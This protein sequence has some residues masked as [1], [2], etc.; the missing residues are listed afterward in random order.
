MQQTNHPLAYD[1]V[2]M[3]R[4]FWPHALMALY[5]IGWAFTINYEVRFYL[6][7]ILS[8]A[9][10]AFVNWKGT[11]HKYPLARSMLL[12]YCLWIV[13]IVLADLVNETEI[14]NSVRAASTPI[15]G[16]ITFVF[17]LT[18]VS[19]NER[20]F[21]TFLIATA[22][23]KAV[24]GE[25]LYG[26]KSIDFALDVNNALSSS[27]YFK[28]RF[29]PFITPSIVFFVCLLNFFQLRWASY[30]VFL[31][32]A[33]TYLWLD[34]RSAGVVLLFSSIITI[35]I[36]NRS[37]IDAA[38]AP[39]LFVVML[40]CAYGI[41]CI[42]TYESL[43]SGVGHNAIQ[44]MRMDNPYNPFELLMQG[45]SEWS[46]AI[47][48]IGDR[49]IF[50]F[51]SWA[52]DVGNY[53]DTLML[54]KIGVA[55]EYGEYADNWKY[56]PVHS[57]ILSSWVWSGILGLISSLYIAKNIFKIFNGIFCSYSPLL[58]AAV[59]CFVQI[60]WH[61]LFS[62]PQ[63]VRFFFPQALAIALV[64]SAQA[65]SARIYNHMN[66]LRA[67]RIDQKWGTGR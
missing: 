10:V 34:A 51:G 64:L 25:P 14:F 61:V 37:R 67:G 16:G 20:S 5:G 60:I 21:L 35:A 27:D 32:S 4:P 12:A 8:L 9:S 11:L 13:A 42:Y 50:G 66:R 58:P 38:L 57:L 56:I 17:V 40:A 49:P 33:V 59:F 62:P 7:E 1:A 23:A 19:A 39:I 46:I 3:Q 52:R 15:F 31:V 36:Q 28:V 18:V 43:R 29:E 2:S 44:L 47:D 48:V 63:T 30:L 45:R 6:S 54:E 24:F 22:T 53:Y 65:N 55:K 41:Y 26:D